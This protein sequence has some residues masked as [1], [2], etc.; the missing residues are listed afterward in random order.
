MLAMHPSPLLPPKHLLVPSNLKVAMAVAGME[1]AEDPKR[2]KP[3][4]RDVVMG[5]ARA[6]TAAVRD[7]AAVDVVDAAAQTV[8]VPH[9]ANAL[10][11]KVNPC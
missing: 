6:A 11:P 5:A 1:T 4:P 2:A 10:T 3:V 7:V 8:K 9:I